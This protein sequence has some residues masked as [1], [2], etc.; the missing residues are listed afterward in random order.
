MSIRELRRRLKFWQAQLG[1]KDYAIN[2]HWGT[3]VEK[4]IGDINFDEL[5]I[6][7]DLDGWIDWSTEHAYADLVM[8]KRNA[9]EETL[10]H[11]LLHLK[12]EGHKPRPG[13]YDPLYERALNDL[14]RAL[15]ANGGQ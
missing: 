3:F 4:P 6:C 10:V 9:K 11:E 13:K 1:L 15:I 12:L 14:A 7:E 2:L 8:R 5:E